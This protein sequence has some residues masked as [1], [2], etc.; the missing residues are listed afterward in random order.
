MTKFAKVLLELIVFFYL[1]WIQHEKSTRRIIEF[2]LI[3]IIF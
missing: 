2:V 3:I 1:N